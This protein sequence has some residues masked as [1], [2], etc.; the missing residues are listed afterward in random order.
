[1]VSII[2]IGL[3]AEANVDQTSEEY[4]AEDVKDVLP[5][6]VSMLVMCSHA[7]VFP[8]GWSALKAPDGATTWAVT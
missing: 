4:Y 6:K 2:F 1:M 7:E 3:A 8:G 5:V